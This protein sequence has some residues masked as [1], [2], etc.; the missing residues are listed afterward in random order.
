MVD[1]RRWTRLGARAKTAKRL[2]R[3]A[4]FAVATAVRTHGGVGVVTG[5]DVE[6]YSGEAR[7]TRLVPTTRELVFA[8][9]VETV[10]GLPRLH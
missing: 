6:R 10:P 7:L 1:D 5:Y 8:S 2:A 3:E 9:L 4:A